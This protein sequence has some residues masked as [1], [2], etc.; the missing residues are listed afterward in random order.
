MDANAPRGVLRFFH[1]MQDPRDNSGKRHSLVNLVVIAI[2][3]I[4]CGADGWEDIAFFGGCKKTWFESFLDLPHGIPS[5][6]TF[7]RVF[8]R[9]KPDAFEACFRQWMAALSQDSGGKLVA[10]DGK[11]LRRSFDR[12]SQKAAIH[13]VSA[14]C[15]S[16]QTVLG[17]LVCEDKSNE[18]TTLPKLLELLDIG[19]AVVTADAMHCQKKTTAAILNAGADYVL[20]VK[21][22]QHQLH[23]D[24]RLLF[25][26]CMR[27]DCHGVTHAYAEDVDKGHGR[28][29]TRR[30]WTTWDVSWVEDRAAWAGLQSVVRVQSTREIDGRTSVEDHYYIS[31]LSGRDAERMLSLIRGYWSI[32]N[33]LHWRLDVVFQE[34]QRRIRTGHAAENYSRLSRIALNLLKADTQWKKASIKARRKIAGWEHDYL[35]HLLTLE[36]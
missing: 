13:M 5:P 35:L 6:D 32:E 3:A 4:I 26:Q 11:T 16:N 7:G 14:W 36:T 18:I 2:S 10:I 28:L 31:S 22:N 17:Q 9:L 19:G 25:D 23:E 29:E 1:N 20:Q 30:C 34:D 21:E 12:A 27:K 15:Q 33:Q 8:A 24:L